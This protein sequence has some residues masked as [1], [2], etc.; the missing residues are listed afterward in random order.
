[1]GLNMQFPVTT[2]KE[3]TTNQNT[4]HQSNAQDDALLL[5]SRLFGRQ[6]AL[7]FL[8]DADILNEGESE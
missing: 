8:R 2:S 6:C 3:S 5:L 7:D 4:G 1:M